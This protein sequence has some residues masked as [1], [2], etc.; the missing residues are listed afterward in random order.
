MG[1]KE[2]NA[3]KPTALTPQNGERFGLA[4][5][6]NSCHLDRLSTIPCRALAGGEIFITLTAYEMDRDKP[7]LAAVERRS[8]APDL[9]GAHS[10]AGG[11]VHGLRA[12]TG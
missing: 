7:A 1:T 4:A 9:L 10:A 8:A 2:I 11:I 12:G 5:E 6:K 3:A